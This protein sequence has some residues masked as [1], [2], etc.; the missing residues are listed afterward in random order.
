MT[1]AFTVVL[2][3]LLSALT[4]YHLAFFAV[5]L[6]MLGMTAAAVWVHLRPERFT[7]ERVAADLRRF[8]LALALGLPAS[9]LLLLVLRIPAE[10]S[11]DAIGIVALA[12]VAVDAAVP[13]ALA[14]AVVVLALTRVPLPIGRLYA[15]DLVGAAG[16]CLLSVGL[17]EVLDP[18]SAVFA[19]SAL[20]AAGA[21][22]FALAAADRRWRTAAAAAV[23]LLAAA[24]VN[25][26][27]YP[28]SLRVDH[29][30]GKPVPQPVSFDRWN[31]H[32]RVT[33]RPPQPGEPVYWG[34]GAAA[35]RPRVR[36]VPIRIDGGAFTV[37]TRFDGRTEELGWLRYD[38]TSLAHHL[39][40]ARRVA[41]IGAGGGRDVLTALASGSQEIVAVEINGLL[42]DLLQGDLREFAGLAGRGDVEWL[43]EDGRTFL[44]QPGEALDLIQMALVD[45]SASTAAGALTL[46]ENGL[47]TV[48]A[49]RLFLRRL[50]PEGLLSVSRWYQPELPAEAGRTLALAVAAL[51]AE[52]VRQ[53][54][55][56]V[57]MATGGALATVLV[58]RAPF[59]E[60]EL[61]RLARTA[62]RHGFGV[63]VAPGRVPG[64]PVLAAIVAARSPA[65][66]DAA[67]RHPF[68]EL[69][70]PTD[71]R[72]FFFNMLRPSAWLRAE[73][74]RGELGS[75][76]LGGN[77]RATSTLGWILVIALA[78]T[79][80]VIVAPL[81]GAGLPPGL[82]AR[83]FA[84][85]AS[86]FSLIGLAFML[87]E[88][89]LV[90]R[91]SLVLG[92]PIYS[93]AVTLMSLILATGLGSLAS[94]RL[95]LGS[96]RVRALSLG[97]AAAI[98]AVVVV[99]PWVAA[100]AMGR[101]L[102]LRMLAVLALTF[103]LGL[104]AGFFFPVGIRLLRCRSATADAW[105]WG[106]NGA[107]GV[108]GSILAVILSMAFGI[109]WCL[110]VAALLYL[111]TLL[112][113]GRLAKGVGGAG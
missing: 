71:E 86:Y 8:S 97:M 36:Q 27:R 4:W 20:A 46:S 49:W 68:L 91:F 99:L 92:Q 82:R 107:F 101:S 23:L 33:A 29:M 11:G 74:W 40:G 110:G 58:S 12:V 39:R 64:D 80:W 28:D 25:G 102:G 72:P 69:A 67:T 84:A 32:S 57:V 63:L 109:P 26:A 35:P 65:E 41:V 61:A 56:H 93:L 13:F 44:A 55:D 54:A 94:E 85:A 19:L 70:P 3:R 50:G 9:H 98:G 16:G 5:S 15:A 62:R 87:L 17:M 6:A 60:D 106:L 21:A 14:G 7:A 88:I 51:L 52:G 18:T 1:L 37:A 79:L 30:K 22:A 83:D 53:P 48:E 95:A 81:V 104:V 2:T 111:A 10:L 90:L 100:L 103:P 42:I 73:T 43:H 108:L 34:P 59:P 66:L 75:G 78:L 45:T 47:Y 89:G 113:L 24:L 31:S 96:R 38:V 112:P 76:A 105:M 77:K